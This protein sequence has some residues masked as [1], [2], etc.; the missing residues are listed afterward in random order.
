MRTLKNTE[1]TLGERRLIN[2]AIGLLFFIRFLSFLSF[3][4]V[5]HHWRSRVSP[6]RFG[7][8]TNRR[9]PSFGGYGNLMIS[10]TPLH[11]PRDDAARLDTPSPSIA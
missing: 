7:E 11:T 6:L 10:Q 2:L 5:R 1:T 9:S 3:S 8:V 4:S